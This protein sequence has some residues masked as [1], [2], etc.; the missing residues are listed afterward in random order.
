[1]RVASL[2]IILGCLLI[3]SHAA[4]AQRVRCVGANGVGYECSGSE[5]RQALQSSGHT[6]TPQ[7]QPSATYMNPAKRDQYTGSNLSQH[8]SG[9][10]SNVSSSSRQ[11]KESMDSWLASKPG[12]QGMQ[13]R[14]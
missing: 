10:D 1:M 6:G 5:A 14:H 8:S 13:I 12:M 9:G 4:H 3:A 2:S 11:R 7:H